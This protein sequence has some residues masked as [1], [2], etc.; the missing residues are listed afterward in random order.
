MK[1]K[2]SQSVK[3]V[4]MD[5][6]T[7]E[8]ASTQRLP[9]EATYET[10]GPEEQDGLSPTVRSYSRISIALNNTDCLRLIAPTP[11]RMTRSSLCD[12][13]TLESKSEGHNVLCLLLLLRLPV[14]PPPSLP[15]T[16]CKLS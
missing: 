3:E 14:L 9:V 13:R 15:Y 11:R 7:R 12:D 16:E 6:G 5:D 8:T 2:T 1:K 10:G 4:K